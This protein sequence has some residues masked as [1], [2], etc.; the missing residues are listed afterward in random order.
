[1]NFSNLKAYYL[2]FVIN[3]LKIK[4]IISQL[5]I[6]LV[7]VFFII[8]DKQRVEQ[9]IQWSSNGFV[10]FKLYFDFKDAYKKFYTSICTLINK[11]YTMNSTK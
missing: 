4:E 2:I 9:H 10:N 5:S 8:L 1:M 11:Y 6:I 3:K 7:K